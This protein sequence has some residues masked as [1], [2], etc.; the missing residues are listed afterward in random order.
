MQQTF[1]KV[2]VSV[3]VVFQEILVACYDRL[4]L[5]SATQNPWV[6]N[7]LCFSCQG[8]LGITGVRSFEGR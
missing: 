8:L 2:Q 1:R 3:Q 5:L 4:Q 6:L 7:I